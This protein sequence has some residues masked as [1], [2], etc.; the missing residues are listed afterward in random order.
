MET[1]I[2]ETNNQELLQAYNLIKEHIEYLEKE[3]EK[4]MEVETEKVKVVEEEAKE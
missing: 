1:K 2:K 4:V 3:K